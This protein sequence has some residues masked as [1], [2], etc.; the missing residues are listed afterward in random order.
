M[1]CRP[2]KDEVREV[3]RP[4]TRCFMQDTV[5]EFP[6]HC[7][8]SVGKGEGDIEGA[9]RRKRHQFKQSVAFPA[10]SLERSI[11]GFH[12]NEQRRIIIS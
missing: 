4:Y 2:Q 12:Q 9:E 3:I 11:A 10:S 8:N 7:S 5:E 1:R 6:V